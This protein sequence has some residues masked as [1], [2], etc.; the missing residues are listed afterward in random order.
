MF[1]EKIL[2]NVLEDFLENVLENFLENILENILENFLE[3]F[4]AW[5]NGFI[6]YYKIYRCELILDGFCGAGG[7][8]IQFSV[9]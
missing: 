6:L 8:A 3:N 9:R 4:S 2:E 1:L 5:K 7:N